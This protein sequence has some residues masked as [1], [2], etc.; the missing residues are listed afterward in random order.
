MVKISQNHPLGDQSESPTPSDHLE[1]PTS[2]NF[3]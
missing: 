2:G 1:S 3:F